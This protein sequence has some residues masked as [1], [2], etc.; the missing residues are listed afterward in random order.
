MGSRYLSIWFPYLATDWHARKQPHLQQQPFVLKA[1]RQG[2]Q[3]VTAA[4]QAAGRLG[5]YTG[6]PLAEAK[7]LC[8]S[9]LALDHKPGLETQLLQRLA[10]WAVRFT[11]AAAPDPPEG[12]LLDCSGCA[13]LWGGED[14]YR[15]AVL[16][17]LADSGYTAQGGLA[18]TIGAAWALARYG[19][20]HFIAPAGNTTAALLPLPPAALRL[21]NDVTERLGRLGLKQ[22]RQLLEL[23]RPAL[24]RRFGP[25]LLLRLRQAL[26]EEMESLT[27]V[28]PPEPCQERLP[29]IELIL[30][31]T[32]IEIALE[33]LLHPFCE[34]LRNEGL[35]VREVLFRIYRSDGGAQG[36]LVHTSRPVQQEA[37]L[38]RLFSLRLST[39]EPGQ[40]IELFT[41]EGKRVEKAV[42]LQ[43]TFWTKG[44]QL[45]QGALAELIDRL[46]AKLG[47]GVV[48]RYLPAAH[49][50]P[51]RAFQP[52]QSL[53]ELP[54]VDWQ[55]GR[56]R[57]LR[58]LTPPEPVEVTAPIPD[59]PPM[60]FRHKGCLHKIAKADGPERI[61]QEWWVEEGEHRDYYAVEDTEGRRY[62]LFRSGHYAAERK[63]Q[64]FLHGYFG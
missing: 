13:H 32:G 24:R 29:S 48:K 6:M 11:P 63:G 57:P 1:T 47:A 61:E 45:Q 7:I 60:L 10:E 36:L 15:E 44:G 42:P 12:L 14:A 28:Y 33:R 21:G 2:R 3:V 62:W 27:P 59:Y 34:R 17:R 30:T 5:V 25:E 16:K 51:E 35:G 8:P 49:H 56:L 54:S 55:S 46:K 9:L 4:S 18:D 64:W 38:F 22:V 52:A 39:L 20:R 37:H 41:L 19:R 58:L 31:R 50:W 26:G 23:P 43:E 40:G 53:E